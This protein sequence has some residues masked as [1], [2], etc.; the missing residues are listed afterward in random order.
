MN[1]TLTSRP[2][3]P[4]VVLSENHARLDPDMIAAAAISVGATPRMANDAAY[5]V[6]TGKACGL[7]LSG[8]QGAGKDTVA[9][10]VLERLGIDAVQCRVSDA[11]KNEM[12][13]IIAA[14]TGRDRAEAAAAVAAGFDLRDDHAAALVEI[15][16]DVTR[17]ADHGL[18]GRTRTAEIRKALQYHGHEARWETHPNYWINACY[19]NVVPH[20][21]AGRSVYLTD[22][23]FPGEI[24]MA[25]A[26]GMLT[27]RLW[28]SPEVQALRITG[29]DGAPPA[30]ETLNHPGEALL[31][32]YDGFGLVVDNSGD[33]APVVTALAERLEAHRTPR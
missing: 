14:V 7:L 32:E 25:R 3:A 17:D 19:A 20:L 15:L 26:L 5:N 30:P 31:D 24:D 6:V 1:D 22:G 27:A 23:R 33:L 4:G 11:I 29:R 12:D 21:A 16:F 18:T 2:S 9:P 13:G 10:L 8:R 28:I